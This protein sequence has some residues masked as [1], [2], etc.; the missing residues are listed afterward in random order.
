MADAYL[1][2][3]TAILQ[4]H[5][6]PM[7][8]REIIELANKYRMIP[9]HLH[10]K[11][12]HKTLQA[13]ISEN[14]VKYRFKSPFFRVSPGIFYLR[15]L[16]DENAYGL[17]QLSEY[18]AIRRQK[19]PR[20]Q[21]VLCIDASYLKE[22]VESKEEVNQSGDK[23][24]LNH[25]KYLRKDVA[26]HSPGLIKVLS[27]TVVKDGD[28]ILAHQIGRFSDHPSSK[29]ITLG[30]RS[31]VTEFDIDLLDGDMIGAKR[32][33]C[34][35]IMRY[36]SFSENKLSDIDVMTKMHHIGWKHEEDARIAFIICF[37]AESYRSQILVNGRTLGF[38]AP[39]WVS[40]KDIA[41]LKCD[42]TSRFAARLIISR[43]AV[44]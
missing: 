14:I 17:S 1:E 21:R 24:L 39:H 42:E 15:N 18:V 38:N 30:I 22:I 5:Q 20:R 36:L 32:S 10:G 16:Q 37:D 23:I 34:R 12:I 19:S 25:S 29:N 44:K 31:F 8:S 4:V 7:S 43:E 6:R 28:R 33:A 3:A 13:R 35:E 27:F 40:S 41:H 26:D 2:L 11:T 9:D